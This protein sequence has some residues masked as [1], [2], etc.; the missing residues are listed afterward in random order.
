MASGETTVL[1]VTRE[2]PRLHAYSPSL[3]GFV[4]GANSAEE[5]WRDV[6][7]A[8]VWAGG[9]PDLTVYIQKPYLTPEGDE[10]LLRVLQDTHLE[11]RTEI[12]RRIYTTVMETDQRHEMFEKAAPTRTGEFV[13]HCGLFDDTIGSVMQAL[14]ERDDAAVVAAAV[15][16]QM[17]YAQQVATG[18]PGP[19]AQTL[20]DLGLTAESTIRDLMQ[21][22]GGDKATS[23]GLVL[24]RPTVTLG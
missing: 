1:V 4:F 2:D 24:A 13:F 10:W 22:E 3:P 12:A 5:F 23:E 14:W 15:A 9:K 21:A 17:W 20:A 8:I 19:G 18:I 6:N 7:A 11:E 16:E